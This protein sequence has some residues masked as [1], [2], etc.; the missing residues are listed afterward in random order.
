[1]FVQSVKLF[2]PQHSYW[3]VELECYQNWQWYVL[4]AAQTSVWIWFHLSVTVDAIPYFLM[5]S[6]KGSRLSSGLLRT[7]LTVNPDTANKRTVETAMLSFAIDGRS[8]RALIIPKIARITTPTPI[9]IR[10]NPAAEYMA[11]WTDDCWDPSMRTLRNRLNFR[12]KC[13]TLVTKIAPATIKKIK[14]NVLMTLQLFISRQ[15]DDV[16]GNNLSLARVLQKAPSLYQ[17][18]GHQPTSKCQQ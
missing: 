16:Q 11:M 7:M 14:A 6:R 18:K 3:K 13:S 17:V 1:M 9:N 15:S 5:E 12:V 2:A 10:E 8:S 4:G